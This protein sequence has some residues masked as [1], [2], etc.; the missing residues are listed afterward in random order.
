MEENKFC[1]VVRSSQEMMELGERFGL[2]LGGK[3]MVVGLCGDLGSG[4]TTFTKGVARGLGIQ[5]KIKSPTFVMLKEYIGKNGNLVHVDAYRLSE[6]FEDIGLTDYYGQTNVLIEWAGNI[7]KLLPAESVQIEFYYI[8]SDI[9]KICV[10]DQR[11]VVLFK[12][13]NE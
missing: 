1:R 9:R 10:S 4:K 2:W 7:G 8:D 6:N 12:E 11:L 13:N 5:E 3:N